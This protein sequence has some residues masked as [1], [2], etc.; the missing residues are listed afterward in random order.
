[1]ELEKVTAKIRPRRNW[2]A[3]DLGFVIAQTTA[4]DLYR[5]W[6]Y[7]TLPVFILLSVLFYESAFWVFVI[8]W[9]LKPIWERPLLHYLSRYLFSEKLTVKECVKATFRLAR[10]QWIMSLLWRRFSFTRS[11]DLPLIQLEGL[12][13][14][15]RRKRL[16]ILHSYDSGTGVWL[17]VILSLTEWLLYMSF[18]FLAMLLVPEQM[19][20]DFDI[21]E[22]IFMDVD[23][24]TLGIILIFVAYLSM[25]IV[26]PFYVACG[27]S[28]YINQRTHLEAWDI[29]LA[30][31]R[32]AIRLKEKTKG[33]GTKL[34]SLA[35]LFCF[36]SLFMMPTESYAAEPEKTKEIK[37]AP[38]SEHSQVKEQI[39]KI[40]QNELFNRKEMDYRYEKI[41][42][43]KEK[44]KSERE[45]D[46]WGGSWF[47]FKF[48]AF[49]AWVLEY[50][51]WIFA[52]VMILY[53]LLKYGSYAKGIRFENRKR[54]RPK[55]LFGLDMDA[56]NLPDQ[57]WVVAEQLAKKGDF[58][59]A[60]SLLYR[61]SLIWFI[62]NTQVNIHE[63]DT[64]MECLGKIKNFAD[65]PKQNFM[66]SLTQLWRMLAYAHQQPVANE[67]IGLAHEW[68]K[69]MK[70]FEHTQGEDDTGNAIGENK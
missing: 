9:W 24:H 3:A 62:D 27:F 65:N 40:K 46:S 26:A 43:D 19:S 32:L 29:E 51:L 44:E 49:I 12:S 28:V 60:L 57:P 41:E 42:K 18:I 38:D 10:I 4:K 37:H 7:I 5:I 36:S 61:A 33:R 22:L 20:F 15:E 2:E 54:R 56:E 69:L 53:L 45:S 67:V 21:A 8:F 14:E 50:A 30:F 25:S 59:Q 23:N 39:K 34:A 70:I 17:T 48:G 58:R 64:E 52:A 13:G 66:T 1:M 63:G 31:K 6:F 68:P 47:F 55:T 11:I 16:R 35:L